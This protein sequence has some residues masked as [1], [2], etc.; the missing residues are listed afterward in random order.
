MREDDDDDD[1]DNDDHDNGDGGGDG[2]N[3]DNSYLFLNTCCV[4]GTPYKQ[5]T[6]HTILNIYYFSSYL[7]KKLSLKI[8][9]DPNHLPNKHESCDLVSSNLVPNLICLAI[10]VCLSEGV[11]SA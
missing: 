8:L 3:D 2:D 11:H 4:P 10:P 5:F 6:R 7:M 1:D 9:N